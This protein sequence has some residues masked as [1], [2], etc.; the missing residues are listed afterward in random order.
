MKKGRVSE[1]NHIA[2][3]HG[4]RSIETA[5]KIKSNR[6]LG[7][8]KCSEWGDLIGLIVCGDYQGQ[9]GDPNFVWEVYGDAFDQEGEII[10]EYQLDHAIITHWQ[11]LPKP[12]QENKNEQT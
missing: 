6:V 1:M 4:W 8:I 3:T 9:D 10:H 5:P 12:P 7:A 11:P 2:C